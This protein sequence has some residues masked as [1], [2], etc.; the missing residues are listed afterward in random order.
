MADAVP[1]PNKNIENNPMQSS[2]GADVNGLPAKSILTDQANQRHY[3]SSR[4]L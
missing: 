3:P 4:N 2:R 1:N